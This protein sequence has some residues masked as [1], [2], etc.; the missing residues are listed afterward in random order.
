M[1][2]K[3]IFRYSRFWVGSIYGR[4]RG[5]RPELCTVRAIRGPSSTSH[6][7]LSYVFFNFAL[8]HSIGSVYGKEANFQI[9]P[10]LGGVIYGRWRAGGL[11]YVL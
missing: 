8:N 3:P 9:W 11:N 6:T 5:G 10:I 1:G 2:R 7:H 4:W